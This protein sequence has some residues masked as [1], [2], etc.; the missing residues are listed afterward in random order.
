MER[1]NPLEVV[2]KGVGPTLK[3]DA[4]DGE[5][6]GGTG[7]VEGSSTCHVSL[8]HIATLGHKRTNKIAPALLQAGGD[9]KR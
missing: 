6:G 4:N 1:I 7:Q 9:E 8:V 2:A 3:E 5:G